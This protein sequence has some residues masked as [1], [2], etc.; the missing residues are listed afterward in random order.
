MA[1]W[2]VDTM[3][4]GRVSAEAIGA[5]AIGGHLFFAVAIFGMGMLL[6][7]DYVVAHACGSGKLQDAHEAL[8]QGVYL[9]LVLA[10]VLTGVVLVGVRFL[11]L[12]G[13]EPAV[14]EQAACAPAAKAA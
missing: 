12:L 4:V 2:L 13:L 3:M 10:L 11:P 9:S 5:V 7:L 6:G 14:L 8:V 1:M